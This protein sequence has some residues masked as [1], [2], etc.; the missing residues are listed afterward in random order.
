[1]ETRIVYLADDEVVKIVVEGVVVMHVKGRVIE[2]YH[3][4]QT[5]TVVDYTEV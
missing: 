5:A 3:G 1:M 4:I 2:G